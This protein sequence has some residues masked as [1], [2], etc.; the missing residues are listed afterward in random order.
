M[1]ALHECNDINLYGFGAD[2]NG[3]WHHYYE[4]L[5]PKLAGAFKTTG[6][7]DIIWE[8]TI[9]DQLDAKGI[10]Q[11]NIKDKLEN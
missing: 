8:R 6:V 9:I 2:K 11:L 10:I 5:P 4:N 7:H 1:F 3:N